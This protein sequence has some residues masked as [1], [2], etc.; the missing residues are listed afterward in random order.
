VTYK[1]YNDL[2]DSTNSRQKE[3]CAAQKAE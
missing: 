1:T 2:Q 3:C